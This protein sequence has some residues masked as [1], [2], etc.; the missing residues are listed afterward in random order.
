MGMGG[1]VGVVT[2]IPQ[3]GVIRV[4]AS[5]GGI[6]CYIKILHT[7][8][9]PRDEGNVVTIAGSCAIMKYGSA[10]YECVAVD[11]QEW[12]DL[13]WPGVFV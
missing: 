11:V 1:V 8:Y 3:Y 2:Q 4:D 10:K 5:D 12:G 7:I 9:M 6:I 13:D